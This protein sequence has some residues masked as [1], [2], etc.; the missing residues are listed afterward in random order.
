M[1]GI[2]V[3]PFK[4]AEIWSVKA[5]KANKLTNP[6]LFDYYGYPVD[7]DK[8]A[9]SAISKSRSWDGNS[10]VD[11]ESF[12]MDNMFKDIKLGSIYFKNGGFN[13]NVGIPNGEG[14]I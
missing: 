14:D 7:I 13:Y 3:F 12:L 10:W 4:T 8:D 6:K 5:S 1:A 11:G 2:K 9:T